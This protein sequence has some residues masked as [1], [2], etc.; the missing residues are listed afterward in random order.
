[1]DENE[2]EAFNISVRLLSRRE[3]ARK[4]IRLKL[5]QRGFAEDIIDSV[6]DQLLA[7]GYQS[8]ARF[9]MHFTRFR[10]SKG[11]GPKRIRL[12]LQQKGVDADVIDSGFEQ[13][14]VDWYARVAEV[15]QKKFKGQVADNWEEKARQTRF[16]DYRGFTTEQ[17]ESC[18]GLD[19]D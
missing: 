4:E 14:D 8:D 5:A 6:L 12:E 16:L 19:F 11:Y 13:S 7:N 18:L 10:A 15:C 3:Y 9:A 2:K 17:I 1:M